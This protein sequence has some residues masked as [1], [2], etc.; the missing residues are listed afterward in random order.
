MAVM[1]IATLMGKF[2]SFIFSPAMMFFTS[3]HGVLRSRES[4]IHLE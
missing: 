1:S 4:F 3:S 2:Y